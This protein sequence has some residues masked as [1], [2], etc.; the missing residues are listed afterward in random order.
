[1]RRLTTHSFSEKTND[2]DAQLRDKCSAKKT[3]V[4][5]LVPRVQKIKIRKLAVTEFYWLL[6]C[7]GNDKC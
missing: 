2:K 3:N 6:I 4:N 5:P 7:K 1:M